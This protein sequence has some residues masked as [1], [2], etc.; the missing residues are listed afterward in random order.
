MR[1][2]NQ[3]GLP[4]C[5]T[6]RQAE[7]I[8][9]D[10]LEVSCARLIEVL[11]WAY[12]ELRHAARYPDDHWLRNVHVVAGL[13]NIREHQIP[14]NI[15]LSVGSAKEIQPALAFLTA[16]TELA[17]AV[18]NH[19]LSGHARFVWHVGQ[20]RAHAELTFLRRADLGH[21]LGLC[22]RRRTTNPLDK[23][24]ATLLLA[25]DV[26]G[27]LD[28]FAF[29]PVR[30]FQTLM[31]ELGHYLFINDHDDTACIMYRYNYPH[32]V[33]PGPDPALIDRWV[34]LQ[35]DL[36]ETERVALC[37]HPHPESLEPS[38]LGNSFRLIEPMP[39]SVA[40]DHCRALMRSTAVPSKAVQ[41]VWQGAWF[42]ATGRPQLAL[43]SMER[44]RESGHDGLTV[45]KIALSAMI[46]L[47]DPRIFRESA[48]SFR[49]YPYDP[50]VVEYF[51]NI[52]RRI[53]WNRTLQVLIGWQVVL[54]H[55]SEASLRWRSHADWPDSKLAI[56]AYHV[57]TWNSPMI[58]FVLPT[59]GR[60]VRIVLFLMIR[61]DRRQK[62]YHG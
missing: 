49:L 23:R 24:H 15:H 50:E 28:P 61:V 32:W 60:I 34:H 1:S 21:T 16:L 33:P 59:L 10:Y 56:A 4:E 41:E 45:R 38:D 7:S 3:S 40:Y 25:T 9:D 2:I 52:L 29:D 36:S 42:N 19:C 5:P 20:G 47:S 57:R 17:A 22:H 12:G 62:T 37:L 39:I 8:T 30:L 18:W 54:R 55:I 35:K 31:H 6:D 26:S 53:G 58:N 11:E 46:T 27:R 44:C 13:W 48:Q 51:I 43:Q 14:I